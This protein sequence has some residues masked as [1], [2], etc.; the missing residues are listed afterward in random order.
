VL[1]IAKP[2]YQFGDNFSDEEMKLK[3]KKHFST[4][5]IYEVFTNNGSGIWFN[6]HYKKDYP[7]SH[8]EEQ[9]SFK[10]LCELLDSYLEEGDYCELYICW[11]GDEEEERSFELDQTIELWNLTLTQ[12]K[13]TRKHY[14][15][16]RNSC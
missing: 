12:F 8:L 15:L 10:A 7:K 9:E 1:T 5:F 14:W 6:K 16:L 2:K 4:R 13:Y 3:V 11:V